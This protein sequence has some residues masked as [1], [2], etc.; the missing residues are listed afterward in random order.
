LKGGEVLAVVPPGGPKPAGIYRHTV[1][2][3]P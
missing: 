1:A 2:L 3:Q